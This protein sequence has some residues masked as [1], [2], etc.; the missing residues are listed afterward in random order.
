[1]PGFKKNNMGEII[2]S[3]VDELSVAD[4]YD[5]ACQI[6]QDCEALISSVGAEP[7]NALIKKVIVSLELLER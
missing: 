1:M 7:V 3:T 4:V 5:L 6:G 2:F